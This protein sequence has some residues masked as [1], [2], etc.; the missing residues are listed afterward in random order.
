MTEA[1]LCPSCGAKIRA[2][3]GRCPR[4]RAKFLTA[5]AA[6]NAKHNSRLAQWTAAIAAVFV[7]GVGALWFLKD[8]EP[9][10][11]ARATSHDP[12]ASR[13][14]PRTQSANPVE[15]SKEPSAPAPTPFLEP[16]GA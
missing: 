9:V 4:C 13:R 16:S 7:L 10:V 6:A 15:V 1:I 8:D 5:D 12:L 11:V 14:Q 2:G 3:H